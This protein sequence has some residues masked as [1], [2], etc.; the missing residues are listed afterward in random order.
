MPQKKTSRRNIKLN[1]QDVGLNMATISWYYGLKNAGIILSPSLT[2]G[3]IYE[4]ALQTTLNFFKRYI[5]TLLCISSNILIFKCKVKMH[6][7]DLMNK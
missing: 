6:L 4:I 7:S 3:A 5:S 1:L 2:G